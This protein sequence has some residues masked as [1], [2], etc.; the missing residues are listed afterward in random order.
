MLGVDSGC[1][2]PEVANLA[3][4]SRAVAEAVA[5]A[6]ISDGLAE[7]GALDLDAE[8]IAERV[9][10]NIWYPEYLPYRYEAEA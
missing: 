10:K 4:V 5:G 9:A 8:S 3:L 1:V 6:A 2:Y 7:T